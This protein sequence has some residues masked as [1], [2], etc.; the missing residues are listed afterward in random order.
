MKK[1]FTLIA[2][3]MMAVGAQ[4]QE[5][6]LLENEATYVD[7]QELTTENTKLVL[8]MDI[9]KATKWDNKA[10]SHKAYLNDFS[11]ILSIQNSETGEYEDKSRIVYIVGGNNPKD[12][13][14]NKGGGFN[15]ASETGK[16]PQSGT[17][18]M[19]TPAK[20]G[21]IKA[22]IILNADKE[23]FIVD[24]TNKTVTEDG[25][26]TVDNATANISHNNYT[27]TVDGDEGEVLSYTDEAPTSGNG[28]YDGGKGGVKVVDKITGTVRFEVQANHTYYI[29]CTGSKL[30][31]FGYVFM[32]DTET[33]INS[34]NAETTTEAPAYNLAGQKVS[35]NF[36]G[37]MIQNGKK[38][39]IK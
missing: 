18:F 28:L 31:F 9:K 6:L 24:A 22:G 7:G 34:I 15:G 39:V 13:K 14:E 38:V 32:P 29:F 30:S 2:I 5:K 21:L 19:I 33:G 1:I 37:I 12:D 20:D 11:Q 4:A 27:I 10:S 26:L 8:G 17:Y 36:K 16:L 35:K 25:Y 23:F 3:A